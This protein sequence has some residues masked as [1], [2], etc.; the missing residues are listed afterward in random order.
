MAENDKSGGAAVLDP[1][2]VAAVKLV[3]NEIFANDP[4]RDRRR[5]QLD[6]EVRQEQARATIKP[7][8]HVVDKGC[9]AGDEIVE[10]RLRSG[11]KW[12]RGGPSRDGKQS[13]EFHTFE[14]GSVLKIP[15]REAWNGGNTGVWDN[16]EEINATVAAVKAR[17]AQAESDHNTGK[18]AHPPA[19]LLLTLHP[20]KPIRPIETKQ[21]W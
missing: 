16:A 18:R 4:L 12:P 14:D 10:A 7:V 5:S 2:T 13:N 15:L 11:H 1:K 19:P 17:H 20:R 21:R 9:A 3:V 8:A 6:E